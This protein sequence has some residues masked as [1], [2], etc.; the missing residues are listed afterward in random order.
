MSTILVVD[1][2]PAVCNVLRL[3]LAR[4]GHQAVVCADGQTALDAI[5]ACSFAGALIDLNLPSIAGKRVFEA[6]R[7]ARP[8]L[9]VVVMSGAITD[10][11][12]DLWSQY[13]AAAGAPVRLLAKPF[14]ASDLLPLLEMLIAAR[15]EGLGEFD[16]KSA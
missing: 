9:P 7:V 15:T 8:D 10:A 1:D 3:A 6:V 16:R 14:R 2:E 11:D 5:A 13:A 12:A 4:C